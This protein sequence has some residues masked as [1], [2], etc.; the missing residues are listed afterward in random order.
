M[1]ELKRLVAPTFEG[2]TEVVIRQS[3]VPEAMRSP[4]ARADF[5]TTLDKLD[6][7][8]TTLTRKERP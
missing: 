3:H 8:L 1:T 6:E 7:Y 5:V 2:K 4:W